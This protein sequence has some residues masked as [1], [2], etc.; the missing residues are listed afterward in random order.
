MRRVA[1]IVFSVFCAFAAP[2]QAG[3]PPPSDGDWPCVQ[4]RAGAISRAAVWSGPE[5]PASRP[6]NEDA[7]YLL[8]RKLASRRTPMAE[9]ESLIDQFAQE[10]G[11]D[12]DERLTRVFD[13]ALE[14]INAERD[15][16]IAGILRYA[17]GQKIL[18]AKVREEAEKISDAQENQ[19]PLAP[20]DL[21][22]AHPELKWDKRIFDDR[23]RALTAVCETPVLLEKRAFAIAQAL[24]RRL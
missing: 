16:V 20:D 21:E 17:R 1:P 6:D 2:A 15:K 8:A 10:A 19:E 11:A 22:K 14:L 5:T 9:A 13:K 12:K 7:E 18:A 24:Q 3:G 23:A 4:R